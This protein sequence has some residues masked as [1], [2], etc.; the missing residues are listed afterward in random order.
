MALIISWSMA[1]VP[2]SLCVKWQKP[3]I[4]VNSLHQTLTAL[5][6]IMAQSPRVGSQSAQHRPPV[7]CGPHHLALWSHLVYTITTRAA[8][9]PIAHELPPIDGLLAYWV[10]RYAGAL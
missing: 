2:N 6:Q 3:C 9:Q 1:P 4:R 10:G 7:H 5:Q 8:G